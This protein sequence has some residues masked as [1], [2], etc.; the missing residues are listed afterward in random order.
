MAVGG[1]DGGPRTMGRLASLVTFLI[2]Q[3]MADSTGKLPCVA[4]PIYTGRALDFHIL[5]RPGLPRQRIRQPRESLCRNIWFCSRQLLQFGTENIYSFKME[6]KNTYRASD[7]EPFLADE[8]K[9]TFESP[10]R[11]SRISQWAHLLPYS[12]ALNIIL[13]LVILVMWTLKDHGPQKAYIPN[14]VF[15]KSL[16]VSSWLGCYIC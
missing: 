10:R 5:S 6:Q 15:C 11:I 16:N 3:C 12:G 7:E 2:P 9:D 13:L 1:V 8:E 14:E 4:A